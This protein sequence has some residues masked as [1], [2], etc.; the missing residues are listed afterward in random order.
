MKKEE[1]I[2][3]LINL[4]NSVNYPEYVDKQQVLVTLQQCLDNNMDPRGFL[5][6]ILEFVIW[7]E[8]FIMHKG[9]CKVSASTRCPSDRN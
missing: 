5:L 7:H 4:A 2:A 3:Y 8:Q 9:M 6:P 1:D